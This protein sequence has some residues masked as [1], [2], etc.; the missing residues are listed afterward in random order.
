MLEKGL[1]KRWRFDV[2]KKIIWANNKGLLEM[3]FLP[4]KCEYLNLR[5]VVSVIAKL[6]WYI[7]IGENEYLNI[8]VKT[9]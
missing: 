8:L 1:K 9:H 4:K 2:I 5:G 7:N 3:P 6:C